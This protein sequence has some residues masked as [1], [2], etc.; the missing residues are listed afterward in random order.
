MLTNINPNIKRLS[1]A[2]TRCPTYPDKVVWGGF[3]LDKSDLPSTSHCL[4]SASFPKQSDVI[5]WCL[6]LPPMHLM[7]NA[8]FCRWK[9]QSTAPK[10]WSK[11]KTFAVV[12]SMVMPLTI[13]RRSPSDHGDQLLA[14]PG[15]RWRMTWPIPSASAEWRDVM[16]YSICTLCYSKCTLPHRISLSCYI[17]AVK[18]I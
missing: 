12:G 9:W 4:L 6:K 1:W 16:T 8:Y 18:H 5:V 13:D 3:I 2:S 10:T 14:A 17:C 7:P 15:S 11:T